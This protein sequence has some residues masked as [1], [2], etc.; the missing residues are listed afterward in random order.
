MANCAVFLVM[1]ESEADRHDF[2]GFSDREIRPSGT[3]S[4]F[5]GPVPWVSVVGNSTGGHRSHFLS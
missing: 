5:H 4:I 2:H 3:G 1:K